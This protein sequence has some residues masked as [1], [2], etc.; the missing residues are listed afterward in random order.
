MAEDGY[1]EQLAQE[2][3]T[4]RTMITE[5]LIKNQ[6]LRWELLRNQKRRE[7]DA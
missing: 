7:G 6:N 5:L 2:N 1:L 3:Q 4:L